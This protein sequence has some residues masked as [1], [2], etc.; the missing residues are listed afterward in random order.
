MFLIFYDAKTKKV[1]ALNGSGRAPA[2]LSIAGLR[3]KGIK[4]NNIPMGNINAVT[5]PGAAA[6]WLTTLEIFGTK[7]L[8]VEE[9]LTPAIKLAEEGYPVSELVALAWQVWEKTIKSASP[10][11][12]EMLRNGHAPKSGEIFRNPTLAETFRTLAREGQKGFYQGR[13]GHAIVDLIQSLGGEMT[14]EDLESHQTDLVEAI[15]IHYQGLDIWEC[16][17]NGQGIVALMALGI[18]D[19]LQAAK[20]IP[21]I[22]EL[23]HNSAEYLHVIIESL[24]L[25]FADAMYYVADPLHSPAPKYLLS[26]P[27]LAERAKLFN[28][29]KQV[30][31]IYRGEPIASSDTVYFSVTDQWGNA[32]SFIN[33]NF[34]GFGTA[35]I[36][37]GCGFT[38]QNRGAGFILRDKEPNCLKGG[39]R[40]YHT[41]IPAMVFIRPT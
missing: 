22:S 30:P 37:K 12:D 32:A 34:G 1:S 20:K 8:S 21:R 17:P 7:K 6:G 18:I 40:P 28:P 4:G 3:K 13:I 33:S 26:K 19:E 2:S 9:I 36:P 16:P 5:V 39:K 23:K 35:A 10:N 25:A 38:L 14:L 15:T 27:Y 11:G 41:I 29:H 31:R 24:R